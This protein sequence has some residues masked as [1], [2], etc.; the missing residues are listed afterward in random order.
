MA[1]KNVDKIKMGIRI[2]CLMQEKGY[3]RSDLAKLVFVTPDAVRHWVKGRRIP[4]EESLIRLA[5]VLETTKEYI[6]YGNGNDDTSDNIHVS[7]GGDNMKNDNSVKTE[8]AVAVA[9]ERI[10][11]NR[12]ITIM[13]QS[14]SGLMCLAFILYLGPAGAFE[15]FNEYP[16]Y[17]YPLLAT[18]MLSVIT[19]TNC[20]NAGVFPKFRKA[21]LFLGIFFSVA[22]LTIVAL[23]WLSM[24]K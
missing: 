4:N 3:S 15:K 24:I 9:T 5:E 21:M 22:F 6:L 7:E 8:A 23:F 19:L 16:L 13:I 17:A 14:V 20:L 10:R 18:A 11:A 2:E 1:Y 12:K